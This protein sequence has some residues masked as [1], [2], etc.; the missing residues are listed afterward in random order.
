MTTETALPTS[1]VRALADRLAPER[2][3]VVG[4]PL[5]ASIRDL[6][7]LRVFVRTHVFAVFDFMSLLKRLQRELT[8]VELPWRPRADREAVRLVNE[9]V[10][11]EESDEDGRGG[12]GSHFELYLA[13]MAELG[14]DRGPIERTLAVLAQGR[15]LPAALTAAGVSAHA[16]RFVRA[17]WELCERGT[18]AEV[19]A[20]FA[21]GREEI[22]PDMFLALVHEAEPH[23]PGALSS[24]RY[25]LERHI[26]LD[27]DQHAPH[28]LRLLARLGGDDEHTWQAMETAARRA[29]EERKLLWDG[30]CAEL[31]LSRERQGAL[32][33]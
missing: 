33:P 14:A 19:A 12:H 4:H 9:L 17:T 28:A 32:R 5:Y 24:L 13:S 3:A 22:L 15:D 30:V 26:H 10:L 18:C 1:R 27:G 2:A 21:L 25:Y 11:A 7:G 31:D 8:C 29:L 20:A 16:Q 6:A 23:L